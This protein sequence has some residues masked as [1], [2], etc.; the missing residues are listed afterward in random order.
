ML[1]YLA[2]STFYETLAYSPVAPIAWTALVAGC[3]I[4]INSDKPLQTR[5]F[6]LLTPLLFTVIL[7]A[8]GTIFY[9]EYGPP[10]NQDLKVQIILMI[11]ALQ[12]L[13][14]GVIVWK[15][16]GLRASS[17]CLLLFLF[18]F[19]AMAGF[20]AAMSVTGSWL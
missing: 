15:L 9:V 5:E 11:L 3:V 10:E 19:S 4:R 7:I 18:C 20:I 12:V 2:W 1:D 6:W 16:R 8:F 17:A 13:V 14:S